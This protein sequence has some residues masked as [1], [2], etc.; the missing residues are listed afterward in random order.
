[1]NLCDGLS[2][3]SLFNQIKCCLFLL[4]RYLCIPD[5]IICFFVNDSGSL[6]ALVNCFLPAF[7][8]MAAEAPGP[9]AS[10]GFAGSTM[11]STVIFVISF[12]ITLYSISSYADL[13]FLSFLSHLYALYLA[14]RELMLLYLSPRHR[15]TIIQ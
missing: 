6:H 8:N 4:W 1:M 12:R 9:S 15:Y 7:S 3:I 13:L 2:C 10:L 5:C 14:P 11:A